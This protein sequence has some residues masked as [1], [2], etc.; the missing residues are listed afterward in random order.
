MIDS[1]ILAKLTAAEVAL[2]IS[3]VMS[4]VAPKTGS[5][6]TYTGGQIQLINTPTTALPEGCTM[7][8]AVTTENTA[9]ADN[10][11]SSDIP[12]KTEAGT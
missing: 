1:S 7:I 3:Q 4:E 6:M 9:P 11:Y 12:A 10:L 2:L 5:D 8:Y